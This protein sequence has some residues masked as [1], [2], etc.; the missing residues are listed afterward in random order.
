MHHRSRYLLNGQIDLPLT[1]WHHSR[2]RQDNN[3]GQVWKLFLL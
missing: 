3:A 2:T 1:L